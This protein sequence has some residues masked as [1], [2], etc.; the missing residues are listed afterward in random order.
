VSVAANI[1]EGSGRLS[2]KEF[3]RFLEISFASAREAGYYLVLAGDLGYLDAPTA[4]RLKDLQ[5]RLA[6]SLSSFIRKRQPRSRLG[7]R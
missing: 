5:G 2:E 7:P 1:V 4:T 3:D 6:A